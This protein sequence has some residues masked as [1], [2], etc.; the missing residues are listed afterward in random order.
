MIKDP[1]GDF[2][3]DAAAAADDLLEV[4]QGLARVGG[5]LV[6]DTRDSQIREGVTIDKAI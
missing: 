3:G 2:V 1:A 4:V 6:G 5:V